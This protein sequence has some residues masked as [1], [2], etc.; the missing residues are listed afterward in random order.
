M[1]RAAELHHPCARACVYVCMMY[2][3][4]SLVFTYKQLFAKVPLPLRAH[5]F[6]VVNPDN[7]FFYYVEYI[8]DRLSIIEVSLSLSKT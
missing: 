5:L 1:E 2:P 3:S 8:V 4:M 7:H 6:R